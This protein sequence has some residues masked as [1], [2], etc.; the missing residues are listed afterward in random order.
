MADEFR[1]TDVGPVLTETEYDSFT[2][3]SAANQVRG[4]ILI[5]NTG[6]TGFIRL[7]KGTEGFVLTMGANDP[8]R[9]AAAGGDDFLTNQAFS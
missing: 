5:S 6:A 4:D 9:A 3:H 7:A 8:T 2:G 1:H